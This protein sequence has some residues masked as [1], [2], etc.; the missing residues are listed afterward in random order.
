MKISLNW[1][2]DYVTAGI[3]PEKLAHRLTMAGLEVEKIV[4]TRGDTVFEMEITPNRPD[5]LS[6]VGVAR[7][8][9]AIL[10]KACRFPGTKKRAR[11]RQK[12]EVAVD[13][14]RGCPRYVGTLIENVVIRKAPDRITKRLGAIGVKSI[15]NVV[16]I[17]NFCL[18]EN[19]QPLHAFDYDRLAGGKIVVRR[20][21][22]GE[23]IV[24][25]D[26]AER[27]LDPSILVIADEQR[28]VAIAGIMG[29]KDT[30]VTAKTKNILLES[31]YFDPVLIRRASR[32]LGLSSDSS[33]RFERGVDDNMVEGGASRAVA[34][35]LENAKGVVTKRSDVAAAGGKKAQRPMAISAD[36]INAYSGASFTAARYKGILKK[37][38]FHV[39]GAGGKI[40]KVT[41][42][43]FRRD[44]REPVDIVEEVLRV[45]GYDRVPLS[46]PLIKASA[47]AP[48]PG[49]NRRRDVRNLF[50]AQGFDEV[51]TYTMINR[52][53][54][55]RSGQPGAE[56]TAVLN[57]LT[58]DQGI[59]RPS[60]LPSLLPV[61]L[62]N[63]NRGQKNIK[64][65]E[66]GKIYTAK[67]EQ[68]VLGVIMTG[69]RSDDWRRTAKEEV[70]YY[71]L[72]GALEQVLARS[73][74]Q[75]EKIQFKPGQEAYFEDGRQSAVLIGGRQVGV[76]GE[77]DGEVLDRWG[78]KKKGVYF[79]QMDMDGIYGREKAQRKYRP[80]PAFPAVCRDISLA[81]N[82]TVTAYEIEQ[83]IRKAAQAERRVALTDVKFIEKYEGDKIPQG[84]R[85]LVFSLTYQ[86]RL[87][88]TLRDEE[89]AEVHA[90]VCDA[91]VKDWGVI[92]R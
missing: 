31:A 39:A 52:E 22:R 62:L 12:C 8:T 66:T 86:S 34:L 76:A 91:L 19:G 67:G 53:S 48:D 42:P 40:F 2:N 74:V 38:D 79:A 26:G 83:T 71:D 45:I 29:G 84:H 28:P 6:M 80:V 85:G 56:G 7:E 9:A 88:R 73:G 44:I 35:I 41:P 1:L 23:R 27:E 51:I 30:E 81:V 47:D 58:Q 3:P 54:L 63:I 21:R 59:M 32:K 25:I 4:T 10:D 75:R 16:D 15:N 36:Q 57:P 5:C 61:I 11:P 55:E 68:D 70:D 89:A 69:L 90:K 14:P 18:M 64:F 82:T 60:M 65:F 49:W 20:A 50:L 24:T 77:I 72:K 17:T 43:S 37:L 33:Y 92:H 46:F 13:D 78:I 87:A